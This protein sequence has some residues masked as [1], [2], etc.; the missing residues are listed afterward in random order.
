MNATVL[1][2]IATRLEFRGTDDGYAQLSQAYF[3]RLP[4]SEAGRLLALGCAPASRC[5]PS[6]G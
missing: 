1:D 3:G 2:T 5:A 4:L 6:S